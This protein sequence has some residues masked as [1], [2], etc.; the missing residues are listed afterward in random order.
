[1][2]NYS[3]SIEIKKQQVERLEKSVEVAGD[4]FQNA[5]VE[6]IDVLFAHRD[7][8]DARLELIDTRQEQLSATVNV[9]QALG[10]GQIP[11]PDGQG[12][13]DSHF[14]GEENRP[15]QQLPPP[16]LLPPVLVP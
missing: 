7:L 10:G 16:R 15:Q 4:L 3:K 11:F 2:E 9:Y 6:Y 1:V 12:H 13:A 5:P 14:A 8:R